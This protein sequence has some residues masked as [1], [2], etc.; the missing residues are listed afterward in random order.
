VQPQWVFYC[1]PWHVNV[2][3]AFSSGWE[4]RYGVGRKLD[5][6]EMVIATTHGGYVEVVKDM[7]SAF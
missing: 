6:S 4:I 5:W 1:Y 2:T 3:D 7:K